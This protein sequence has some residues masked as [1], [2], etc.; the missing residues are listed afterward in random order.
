MEIKR[1]QFPST[2]AFINEL[3][4]R[5]R[6]Y[7]DLGG[8]PTPYSALAIMLREL[9]HIPKLDLFILG[10]EEEVSRVLNPAEVVTVWDFYGC[11]EEI[12]RFVKGNDADLPVPAGLGSGSVSAATPVPQFQSCNRNRVGGEVVS[13][14]WPPR[15]MSNE[16]YA[17]R[18]REHRPQ[19]VDHGCV[20]CGRWGH[21]AA[22]CWY[23]NPE[24]R[25]E[26]WKSEGGLWV[27]EPRK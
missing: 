6:R 9:G 12:I 21:G 5:F 15:G 18:W 16:D 3:R 27:F 1:V 14:K 2:E 23:L 22:K 20:Y 11:C 17:R 4:R 8:L 24:L 26:G 25:P 10:K 19:F 13:G 7:S